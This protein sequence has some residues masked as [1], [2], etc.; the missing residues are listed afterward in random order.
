MSEAV[1]KVE[2]LLNALSALAKNISDR[3]NDTPAILMTLSEF[4][5]KGL[6][7]LIYLTDELR[8]A[9]Y[10]MKNRLEELESNEN[11]SE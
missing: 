8:D 1:E 7:D 4:A 9:V 5:E 10:E 3:Y 2:D 11:Q 6:N